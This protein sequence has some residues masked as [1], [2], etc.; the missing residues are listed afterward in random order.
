M[1]DGHESLNECRKCG[2][3]CQLSFRCCPRCGS[4]LY[5]S[6]ELPDPGPDSFVPLLN[7][8]YNLLAV[9]AGDPPHPERRKYLPELSEKVMSRR[10]RIE[11]EMDVKALFM[12]TFNKPGSQEALMDLYTLSL[13]TAL[14]GY[15]YRSVEEMICK[16]TNEPL[17]EAEKNDLLRSM[18]QGSS[19]ALTG[20]GYHVL[21]S[22]DAVDGRLL[23]CLAVRWDNHHLNYVLADDEIQARWWTTVRSQ[24]FDLAEKRVEHIYGALELIRPGKGLSSHSKETVRESAEQDLLH[25]YIV[26]LAESLIPINAR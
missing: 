6:L 14:A 22:S 15:V 13:S 1:A 20:T 17:S 4:Q 11:Y 21:R 3:V 18:Y 25:G 26:K 16:R 2:L 10:S 9:S 24:S 12:A 19:A 5:S 8:L 7:S 23:F